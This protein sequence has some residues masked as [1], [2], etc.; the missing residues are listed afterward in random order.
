MKRARDIREQLLRL[1]E[2]VEIGLSSSAGDQEP[3]RKAI[4]AG[5]FYH[6]AQLQKHGTYCTVK[7]RQIVYIHPSSGLV[8]VCARSVLLSNCWKG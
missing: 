2:R 4:A 3:V 5:F 7:N 8:E 1:M 6:S